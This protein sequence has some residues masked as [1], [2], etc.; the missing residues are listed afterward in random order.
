[1]IPLVLILL[2]C[3]RSSDVRLDCEPQHSMVE[4][5]T[6]FVV[7]PSLEHDHVLELKT[8]PDPEKE[9]E[10]LQ[11]E[12]LYRDP[13]KGAHVFAEDVNVILRREPVDHVHTVSKGDMKAMH[14]RLNQSEDKLDHLLIR[15]KEEHPE[16]A[17]IVEKSR[18]SKGVTN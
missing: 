7:E 3:A 15:L 18:A 6:A 14:R 16:E 5:E 12:T 11:G 9:D 17:K 8:D 4:E 2:S 10:P 13:K 1:M